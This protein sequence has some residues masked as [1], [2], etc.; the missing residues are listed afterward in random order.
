[1]ANMKIP[2][3]WKAQQKKELRQK[4]VV[5]K[6]RVG[7]QLWA[8]PVTEWTNLDIQSSLDRPNPSKTLT[9]WATHVSS[10]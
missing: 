3:H 8:K 5:A 4:Q 1:M 9:Q 2:E 7:K 10:V 6:Q